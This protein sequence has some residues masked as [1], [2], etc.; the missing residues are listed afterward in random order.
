MPLNP[1]VDAILTQMAENPAPPLTAMAPQEARHAYKELSAATRMTDIPIGRVINGTFPGPAGDLAYRLYTPVAA[2]AVMPAMVFYH[3]GGWVIGDLETHDGLCRALANASGC[4]IFAVD[5]RLAPEHPFPAA[6]DDA[7]AAVR[8]V[9]D[10]AAD[11]GIDPNAIAVGG[12]SAGGNLA[13]VVAQQ[14]KT[15]GVQV[16]FQLL[17][18]PVTECLAE[19]HSMNALAKG[20]LLEK[21]AMTWFVQQYVQDQELIKDPRVSPL[22]AEDLSGLAPAYVITAEYDPLR[23]EGKAYADKLTA[24]GVAATHVDY[25]GMIHGFM[26]MGA[27]LEDARTAIEDA[28]AAVRD[29]LHGA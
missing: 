19:T 14:A 23:D 13:A 4:R 1:Q 26:S 29:A 9:Q 8:Y 24:A 21:D 12:D 22:C 15:A 11:L 18:Y 2:V 16:T 17:I 7:I 3:G 5:Y 6:M 28:G 10:N 25:P 20:Y 27:L